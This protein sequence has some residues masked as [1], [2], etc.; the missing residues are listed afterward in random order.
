MNKRVITYTFFFFQL[1]ILSV[2]IGPFLNRSFSE[3]RDIY[4]PPQ[5]LGM[6]NAVTAD[7]YGYFA[8]FYNP[9][10]LA[11][12]PKRKYEIVIVDLDAIGSMGVVSKW[13]AQKSPGTF[14]LTRGIQNSPGQVYFNSFSFVPAFTVR[15]LSV[16]LLASHF[17]TAQ[18]DGTNV[19]IDAG[20]DVAPTVG[21]ATNLAGNLLK[22]G[23]SGRIHV[24]N[25]LKGNFDHALLDSNETI[26]EL[27]AQG[28]GLGLNFGALLTLP[29]KYLPTLGVAW[30]DAL[31]TRFIPCHVLHGLSSS[32]PET[33]PQSFNTAFSIH[34]HLARAY[35]A[36]LSVEL[37]HW[38]Q[39][40]L[41][42]QKRFHA[43]LQLDD[44]KTFYFWLG[45]NQMYW[46][47]GLAYRVNGGN[48]E[49]G[50]YGAEVGAG[51]DR[52]QDRR[53]FFRYTISYQ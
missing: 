41:P 8:N 25:Q 30:L 43:G 19:N 48:L 3:T 38:E 5:A 49:F 1:W 22:V 46:T 9:A 18:S 16:S 21:T 13:S 11:K 28:V 44:E 53:F 15:G 29:F 14:Q 35:K 47:A 27:S 2:L 37:K 24:R 20:Q 23:V 36:T 51:D 31:G 45:L 10:G 32:A 34:P 40:G 12:G 52:S 50:S 17:Y 7:A 39:P 33:I 42:W 6:G 26:Q 4:S